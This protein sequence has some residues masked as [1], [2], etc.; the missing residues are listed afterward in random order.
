M[1]DD[2]AVKKC[3]GMS[4]SRFSLGLDFLGQLT[5]MAEFSKDLRPQGVFQKNL[6]QFTDIN[7]LPTM[8]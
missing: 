1:P 2:C 5:R 6:L 3:H 8:S 7:F 4:S